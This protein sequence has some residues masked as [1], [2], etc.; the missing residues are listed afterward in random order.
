[1]SEKELDSAYADRALFPHK[2]GLFCTHLH[3]STYAV[4]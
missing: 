2:M 4:Y 3:V 1:M